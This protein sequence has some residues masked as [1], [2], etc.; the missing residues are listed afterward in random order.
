MRRIDDWWETLIR[1]IACG[2]TS[3]TFVIPKKMMPQAQKIIIIMVIA[4]DLDL[5]VV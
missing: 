2:T 3:T 1:S 5:F 4:R